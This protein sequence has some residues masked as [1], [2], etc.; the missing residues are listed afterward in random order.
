MSD[1]SVTVRMFGLLHLFRSERGLPSTV[2]VDVPA[3]GTT[4]RALATDL[5]LPCDMIEGVFVN[6]TVYGIDHPVMP[7]DRVAFVPYGTPGPHRVFLGLYD[8]GRGER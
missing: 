6:R 2:E 3:E 1:L 7:G 4:G 8:A 5:G